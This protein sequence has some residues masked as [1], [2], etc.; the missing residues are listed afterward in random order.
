MAKQRIVLKVARTPI[1][2]NIDSEKEE[3]YRLAE[4]KVNELLVAL[5]Q[6][7]GDR[8]STQGRL[9][10]AALQFCIGYVEL[11]RQNELNSEDLAALDALSQRMDKHLNRIKPHKG[12]SSA[13]KK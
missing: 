13:T 10:I 11:S 5:E 7:F 12:E 1:E 4:H 9:S 8:L 3:V 6:S 2:M